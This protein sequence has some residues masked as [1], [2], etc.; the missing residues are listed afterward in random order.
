MMRGTPRALPCF[1]VNLRNVYVMRAKLRHILCKGQ[2][3]AVVCFSQRWVN[4]NFGIIYNTLHVCVHTAMATI[5]RLRKNT[6]KIQISKATIL[7]IG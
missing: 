7:Q 3:I 2:G 1:F 4:T 6:S 5:L